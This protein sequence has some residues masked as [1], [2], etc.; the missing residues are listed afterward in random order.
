MTRKYEQKQ[1]A[2]L[3]AETRQRIVEAT[4]ALHESLGDAGTTV[5]A[6]AQRAGVGRLT[7]YRHFPDE[8]ALLSACT[9]HYFAMNP[10]PDPAAWANV[11]DPCERLRSAL[12]TIYA[13]YR[14]TEGMLARAEAD[15]PGNPVLA[16]LLAP[17]AAFWNAARDDLAAS[18]S[19][20]AEPG[21]LATAAIGHA[22]AF[23][24]WRSLV[25]EQG[26][27]DEQ[28]IALMLALVLSA[29]REGA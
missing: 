29:Q 11:G 9:G 3:Q 4:I 20:A 23:T 18:W 15:A 13:F 26:L 24:T 17:L 21:L 2:A 7:V 8:R 14:R 27:T 10:P 19:P 25:R 28:V 12:C 1:R 22:L 5:T 16:E 6:I